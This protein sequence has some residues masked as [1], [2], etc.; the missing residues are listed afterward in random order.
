MQPIRRA[1]VRR[2]G[3]SL[4]GPL[5]RWQTYYRA[6]GSYRISQ[7]SW[8]HLPHVNELVLR[9]SI[10]T[11]GGRPTFNQQYELWNVSRTSGL[12]R[13]TA[14][15]QQLKPHYTRE[16]EFGVTAIMYDSRLSL[17]L[18]HARQYSRDQIIGLPVPTISGFNSI[19]GNAGGIK[20]HTYEM[21]LNA[22][23]FRS[24]TSDFSLSFVADR[25]YN[26]ITNWGR[27]CFFGHTITTSL[28]NHEYSCDGQHRGDF[29]GAR[30]LHDSSQLPAWLTAQSSEFQV[31]DEGYLVWVGPGN[32]FREGLSKSLWGTQT[33]INGFVYRFGEPILDLD[34]NGVAVFHK[35]GTS[36]PELNF[37][38]T[39]NFRYKNATVYAELRGQ[40]GGNVYNSARQ[41]LYNELRHKDLDQSGKPDE[42]KKTIDYYQRGLYA[43]NRFSE[44]FIESGTYLKVGAITARYR[45]PRTQLANLLGNAAPE[46][47]QIGVT[48]R[49]LL[50]LTGYSGL[51]P[52]SGIALSRVEQ[53]GYPQLRTLTMTF[54][55]TF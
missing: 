20:G 16:Q 37:G 39:P 29:W 44:V 3:S 43:G 40:L 24:Q 28:S 34:K 27:A 26:E 13:G 7:E 55:I 41:R 32:T 12:T 2:D 46:A 45:F 18:V 33:T 52:E 11:A 47:L 10:G 50:T 31:N 19:I 49:N 23:L 9:Y 48:A 53:L 54:D 6:A 21:T 1:T 8:F 17:E 25:S 14:G 30:F 22:T 42:L 5:S 4:F 38:I 15:N 36:T 35:I 51:D